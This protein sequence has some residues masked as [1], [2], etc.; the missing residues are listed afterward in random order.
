MPAT[1]LI[2]SAPLCSRWPDDATPFFDVKS[3]SACGRTA[4]PWGRNAGAWGR[5]IRAWG[6]NG[7]AWGSSAE[8]LGKDTEAWGKNATPWGTN[9]ETWRR[10]AVS[11]L[12]NVVPECPKGH[13]L[14]TNTRF[15]SETGHFEA[16]LDPSRLILSGSRRWVRPSRSE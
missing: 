11:A 2:C 12:G 5:I 4:A 9:D 10:N 1:W 16:A 8:T 7:E 13:V 15:S 3:A 14:P 6:R